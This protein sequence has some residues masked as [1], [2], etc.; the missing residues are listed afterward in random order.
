MQGDPD[1]DVDVDVD[2]VLVP[3][4]ERSTFL[5]VQFDIVRPENRR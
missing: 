2:P 5:L 4:F 3:K 1:L